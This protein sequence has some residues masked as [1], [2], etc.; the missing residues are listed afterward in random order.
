MKPLQGVNL[1]G[2]L[3]LEPWIT[4][5][6]FAGT[7]VRDEYSY[8]SQADNAALARLQKHYDTF[9]TEQDFA[10]LAAHQVQAVRLPVGYWLF[11]G[12]K[13]YQKTV[14]YVD[15]AFA[16]AQKHQL[17]V[18]L[19]LHG[20]VGSQNGKVHSGRIGPTDWP[21]PENID[22]TL[23]LLK[24]IAMR[25]GKQSALLGISLINEPAPDISR[26]LMQSF[27]VDAYA[28]LREDLAP[29]PWIV[30]SDTFKHR[31]WRHKLPRQQY[32]GLFID[33]HHYQIYMLPDK[34]LSLRQQL[35][36]TK[37]LIPGKL[38]RIAYK[39][40][41]I[42][43]EWSLAMRSDKLNPLSDTE[44]GQV[45]RAYAKAQKKAMQPAAAWFYWTYKM[46]RGGLWSYRDQVDCLTD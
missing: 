3:I 27:Y 31:R 13:P 19:D 41:L 5:S 37:H 21:T 20:T 35:W 45:A 32:P 8:C 22:A 14:D 24:K 43:G 2:W 4:P 18:L 28:T 44:R 11:G 10:W 42:I 39:H 23:K 30:F 12:E 40:S 34:L 6:L 7:G 26:Q 33:H 16:W 1:G 36:R 9:I 46:E 15:K 17:K 38:R 29:Q 25:Y